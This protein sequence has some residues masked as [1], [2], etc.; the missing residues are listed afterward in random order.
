M[1]PLE[2]CNSDNTTTVI[3]PH[4]T[5]TPPENTSVQSVSQ[6]KMLSV[7]SEKLSRKGEVLTMKSHY[8]CS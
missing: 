3:Q 8:V 2:A 6:F 1:A 5:R 4:V 7:R